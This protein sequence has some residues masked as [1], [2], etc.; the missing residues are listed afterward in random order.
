[1]RTETVS[2]AS[3]SG[4]QENSSTSCLPTVCPIPDVTFEG[5][6]GLDILMASPPKNDPV[7]S[8]HDQEKEKKEE[9]I[10]RVKQGWTLANVES[11]KIGELYLIVIFVNLVK[12]KL[13][14]HICTP[15]IYN[16]FIIFFFQCGSES[17]IQLEYWF[18]DCVEATSQNRI[19]QSLNKL[20]SIAQYNLTSPKVRFYLYCILNLLYS[21]SNVN[22]DFM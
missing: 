3:G 21:E 12:L 4:S 22:P 5:E 7:T 17:K 6:K 16:H 11:I 20:I 1:M 9:F 14:R 19:S 2:S 18:E 8:S 10:A 15:Y 13:S